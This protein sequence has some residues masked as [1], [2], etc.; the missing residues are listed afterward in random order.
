MFAVRAFKAAVHVP[1]SV[2]RLPIP[3]WRM[4]SIQGG[5]IGKPYR[6]AKQNKLY[7]KSKCQWDQVLHQNIILTLA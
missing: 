6:N 4:T 7:T 5:P 2:H 3:N 1:V